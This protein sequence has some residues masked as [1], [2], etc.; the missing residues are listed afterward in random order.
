MYLLGERLKD[1]RD[2][3]NLGQ[4]DMGKKINLSSSAYGYYEQGRNEPS[5]ETLIKL[6]KFFDVSTDYLLGLSHT[7]ENP[8]YYSVSDTIFLSN[9]EMETLQK[10][11]ET[12]LLEELS[13]DPSNNVDRLHRYWQFMKHEQRK[14]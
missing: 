3:L 4:K 2:E 11:K 7:R 10:M 5:L 9:A 13:E 14:R 8:V 12:S 6:A 1:L